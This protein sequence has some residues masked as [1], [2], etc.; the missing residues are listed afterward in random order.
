[1]RHLAGPRVPFFM[2]LTQFFLYIVLTFCAHCYDKK[3]I[4]FFFLSFLAVCRNTYINCKVMQI[5]FS[6]LVISIISN[7]N[8]ENL[9][10]R[11]NACAFFSLV[12]C[13]LP[14]LWLKIN[15]RSCQYHLCS[16]TSTIKR[17]SDL[18]FCKG[19]GRRRT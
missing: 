1:M 7:S 16:T 3:S 13:T 2:S 15:T 5:I 10:H 8:Y 9:R 4:T 12:V 18:N 14:C 17:T 19:T 11:K 6:N